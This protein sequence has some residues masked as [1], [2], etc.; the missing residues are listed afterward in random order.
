VVVLAVNVG[1]T[2]DK[3]AGFVSDLGYTFT[4]LVDSDD[5]VTERYGVKGIPHT[6]IVDRD[7]EVHAVLAGADDIEATVLRLLER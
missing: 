3:V 4:V 5:R 1:E 6:L 2:R 7:G